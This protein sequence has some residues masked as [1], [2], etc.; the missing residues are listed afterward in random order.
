[1]GGL[2][3]RVKRMLREAMRVATRFVGGCSMGGTG[4][5]KR[6]PQVNSL[7]SHLPRLCRVGQMGSSRE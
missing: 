3:T 6:K 4:K 2:L 1:M 5:R 7:K